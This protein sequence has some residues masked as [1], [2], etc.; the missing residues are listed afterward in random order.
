MRMTISM[1][2]TELVLVFRELMSC[3]YFVSDHHFDA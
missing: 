1:K 2:E 3:D